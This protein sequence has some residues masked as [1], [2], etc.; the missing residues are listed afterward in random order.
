MSEIIAQKKVVEHILLIIA[1]EAEA[2]PLLEALNLQRIPLTTPFVPA[3]AYQGVY[4]N[5]KI[6][7]VTNGI[8]G[9]HKV[10][11]VGTTPGENMVVLLCCTF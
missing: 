1:M 11:N 10:D 3:V 5:C 8:D 2:K 7:V 9:Q 6:S 4:S